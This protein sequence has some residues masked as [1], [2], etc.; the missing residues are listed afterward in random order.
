MV[1]EPTS[2]SNQPNIPV[3][4]SRKP[5]LI[6]AI[7]GIILLVIVVTVATVL[8]L[9]RNATTPPAISVLPTMLPGA[10]D[11]PVTAESPVPSV[12]NPAAA[13]PAPTPGEVNTPSVQ[14]VVIPPTTPAQN[15]GVTL[16]YERADTF[17][18]TIA[19]VERTFATP[20][21]KDRAPSSGQPFSLV[22][23]TD[24]TNKV[25]M[26]EK[27][28]VPTVAIAESAGLDSDPLYALDASTTYLVLPIT[29]DQVPHRIELVSQAGQVFAT[30]E[31]LYAEVP[32]RKYVAPQ[33]EFD[34]VQ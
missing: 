11:R 20:T 23:V 30:R 4:R 2:F 10:E 7:V 31:F 18:V 17:K 12:A 13:V 24:V 33:I 16:S 29:N 22:R 8:L 26:E 9:R 15:L 19:D 32:Q 27:I 21:I 1:A 14:G 6:I 28:T 5:R 34:L 25:I 3:M